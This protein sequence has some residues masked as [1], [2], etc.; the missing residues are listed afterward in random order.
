M[1]DTRNIAINKITG[2]KYEE[3]NKTCNDKFWSWAS[4]PAHQELYSHINVV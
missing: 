1:H 3:N 2:K 4:A